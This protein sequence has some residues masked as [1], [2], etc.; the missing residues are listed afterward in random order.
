[1]SLESTVA[2]LVT[3]ANNLTN[4]VSGK[5]SEINAKVKLATDA[6]PA[7]VRGMSN[8]A[9]YVDA[10]DGLDTNDGTFAKPFKTAYAVQSRMVSGSQIAV[11]FKSRQ[12]HE[13]DLVLRSGRL[14]LMQY[15]SSNIMDSSDRPILKPALG[16]VEDGPYQNTNGPGVTS[17]QIFMHGLNI[18]CDV[19]SAVALRNIA[20]FI[21]YADSHITIMMNWC[22]IVLG[23]IPFATMYT[24]YSARDIYMSSTKISLKSG[25]EASAKLLKNLNEATPTVRF[26]AYSTSLVGITGGWASLLPTKGAENY[27]TNINI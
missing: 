17:G 12:T 27:L 11:Y 23:N 18:H 9:F 10:V 3:A 16:S 21:R 25:Y 15:G 22:D 19:V 13:V 26:E 20:G 24:G 2:A 5:I 7:L 6:V 8:Q 4:E 1:M 14:I